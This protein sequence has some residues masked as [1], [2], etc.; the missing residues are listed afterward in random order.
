MADDPPAATPHILYLDDDKTLVFLVRRLLE[1]R[2]YRVTGFTSQAEAIDALRA[3][4][5]GFDLLLTDFNMPGMSGLEV[6]KAA[7]EINPL[8]P[9]AVASGYIS[10][11]LHADAM[12][13]GVREV[14]FKANAVESFCEAV[15]RLVRSENCGR[16]DQPS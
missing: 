7:L 9:V 1:R 8:L 5:A 15:D 4:P 3:F 11:Q 12:A 6:A 10:D 13:A 14:I 2:G 16:R